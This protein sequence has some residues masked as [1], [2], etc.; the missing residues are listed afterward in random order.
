[1]ETIA[2]I[3]R[4][5]YANK[6]SLQDRPKIVQLYEEGYAIRRIAQA[7]NIKHATTIRHHLQAMGVL[8]KERK[9]IQ[10]NRPAVPISKTIRIAELDRMVDRN[11]PIHIQII[12]KKMFAEDDAM[13]KRLPERKRPK[14]L[15]HKGLLAAVPKYRPFKVMYSFTL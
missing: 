6:I 3:T 14:R 1:M 2:K 11:L 7:F 9:V 10:W 12:Y 15:Q 13:R 8:E 5:S 4:Y